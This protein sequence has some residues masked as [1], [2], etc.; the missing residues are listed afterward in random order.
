LL[1]SGTGRPS[2]PSFLAARR[3]AA[4]ACLLAG[5]RNCLRIRGHVFVL[6]ETKQF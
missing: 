5:A 3:P 2:W 6:D 4:A 1:S